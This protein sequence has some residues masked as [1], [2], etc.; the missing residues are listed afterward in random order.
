MP[1]VANL[2]V[3]WLKRDL[4][5]SD[6]AALYEA[7]QRGPV[8]PVYIVEPA[9]IHAP[10]YDPMHW[11]WIR[12]SLQVLTG[13]LRGR[14][15]VY[16]ASAL[17]ALQRVLDTYGT[18]TLHSHEETGN[19]ITFAR[20]LAVKQWAR[21]HGIAWHEYPQ[22]GV[23]RGLRNR[24]GWARKWEQRMARPLIPTIDGLPGDFAIQPTAIPTHADLG[25]A[26]DNRTW[27]QTP[28]EPAAFDTLDDFLFRRGRTYRQD[29]S[30]PLSGE[31]G[32][33]RLSA[34]LAYGNIS[35]KQVV[36]TARQRSQQCGD[37]TWRQSLKSFDARLHWHCHF[38]QK[39]ESDPRIETENFVRAYDGLREND[40]DEARFDAW[41]QGQTGFPF[42]DA[43]I[44][45][46]KTTGWINFRMRAML[47]SFSSYHLWLHWKRPALE[48]ARWFV[49][50]EPGIHYSQFQMQSGTTG[51]NTLRIYSPT[52]QGLDQD[53][54][55]TFIR[56]WVPELADV[57]LDFLHEPWK[58]TAGLQAKSG[59]IIGKQYP[60]PIVD[61]TEAV[62]LAR[63]RLSAFR[64]T[65]EARAEAKLVMEKHGSRKSGIK[66]TGERLKRSPKPP[67]DGQFRL[68]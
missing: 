57:P 9:V 34:Y 44:R 6:H 22:T 47:V 66:Q 46:L 48:M 55:G 24:N 50:Y 3:V 54:N 53:P 40:F 60:R 1:S 4:R 18:Y 8:L 7:S 19:A 63:Q 64:R 13:V 31:W 32:C 37:T 36:Q 58:M 16:H 51:I 29:M 28:G 23:I 15:A 62:Q 61:H 39:L 59:C 41:K 67:S 45:S 21:E 68:F 12:S 49:D 38:M 11:S 17:E 42:I 26:A 35:L 65:P 10:D 27:S 20:D 2:Q 14:L 25:L 56:R 5:A 33:S 43:C 52:K 30:S